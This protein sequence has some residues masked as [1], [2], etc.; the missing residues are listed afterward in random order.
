MRKAIK[1]VLLVATMA[2]AAFTSARAIN[3][4]RPEY[5]RPQFERADWVNLNGQWTCELDMS[6]TGD[7]RG[8]KDSKGL[9]QKITVPFCPESQLSGIGHTDFI[10]CIWYQRSVSI[11]AEW[12]G[13]R[14]LLQFGAADYETHVYI[15][16]KLAGEHYGTGSSFAI[17]LTPYA[18][19]GEQVLYFNL[20]AKFSSSY[21]SITLI[22]EELMEEYPA[23][24]I[25]VVDSYSATVQEGLL[26]TEAARMAEDGLTLEEA[27]KRIETLKMT[28]RIFFTTA[29]LSY[30]QKGGRVGKAMIQ[31]A[32]MLKIKPMIQLYE[33]ELQAAGIVRSRK[34]SLQ[35]FIDDTKRFF[36]DKNIND[37]R[38]CTGYGYDK[39]E[40][41][42]LY[43]EVVKEMRQL[44]FQGEVEQYHIG[45][46]I[47]VHTGPTPI[48]IAVIRKYD[49]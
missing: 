18:K 43:A 41:N 39:E 30:L 19:A 47:G 10:P 12:T 42:A 31:V 22:A 38:I 34:K 46:T 25:I 32:S 9:S 26:V 28:S 29:D 11:P 1:R 24:K 40:F 6:K 4:P 23:C 2:A 20:T 15:N 8:W 48:G 3:I 13:K 36:K 33:G 14:I 17:D 37:Y 21:Q 27:A 44:G 45:C 35:R 49:A 16:G 7:Q 5:P